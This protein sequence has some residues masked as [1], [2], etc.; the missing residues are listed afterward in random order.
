MPQESL[1]DK[2]PD[3]KKAGGQT[4]SKIA[5]LPQVGGKKVYAPGIV[6]TGMAK[7]Q[8]DT[9]PEY[10]RRAQKAIPVGVLQT[11]ESVAAAFVFLASDAANYMT[12]ATLLVD[13]GC[14]LYPMDD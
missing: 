12:G 4:G 9:E 11:P 14:S 5:K 10:R 1:A 13:G 2:A 6:G 8:W 7:K 3:R